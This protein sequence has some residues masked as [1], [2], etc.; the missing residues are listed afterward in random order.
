MSQIAILFCTKYVV[1]RIFELSTDRGQTNFLLAAMKKTI[2]VSSLK[3]NFVLTAARTA[4]AVSG[5]KERLI[6]PL[7]HR[8]KRETAL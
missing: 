5:F 1:H 3:D 7:I 8:A 6:G 4:S 2:I